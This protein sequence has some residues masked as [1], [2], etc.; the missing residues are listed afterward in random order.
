MIYIVLLLIQ[1]FGV[2]LLVTVVIL[3]FIAFMNYIILLNRQCIR[4][5]RLNCAFFFVS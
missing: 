5:F 3:H 1:N 4:V 2:T